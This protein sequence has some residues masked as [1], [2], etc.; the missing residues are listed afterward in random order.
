LKDFPAARIAFQDFMR[1]YPK[2]DLVASAQWMLQNME[3]S[4]PPP[5]VGLPDSMTIETPTPRNQGTQPKPQ[6]TQLKP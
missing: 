6:G 1:K 4:V 5:E 3:H 2:S